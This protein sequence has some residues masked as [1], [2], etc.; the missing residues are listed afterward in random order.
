LK[1]ETGHTGGAR[2]CIPIGRTK[3]FYN[4][5]LL[6]CERLATRAGYGQVRSRILVL[7]ASSL[8]FEKA[9]TLPLQEKKN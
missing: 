2:A 1:R 3:W 8:K 7:E 9:A 6:N 5:N 4:S